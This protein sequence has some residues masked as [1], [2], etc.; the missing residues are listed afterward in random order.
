MVFRKNNGLTMIELLIVTTIIALFILVAIFA[1]QLQL[2]KGRDARRKA[3]LDKIQN[4]LEDYLNDKICY[5]EPEE[6]VTAEGYI[7][8]KPFAPYLSSLPCDPLNNTYYNYFYSYDSTKTCKG[9]YKIYTKLENTKD[10]IIEKVGCTGG[11][12]PSGNY[13][14]W[15]S[16]PNMNQVAPIPLAEDWWPS[17]AGVSPPPGGSPTPPPGGTPTPSPIP[18]V[19][20]SP[21]PTPT[22]VPCGDGGVQ[23]NCWDVKNQKLYCNSNICSTCCP[24]AEYRCNLTATCCFYDLTCL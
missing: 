14:Y 10:P 1:Y 18:G 21:T 8:G 5:P 9:W 4:V 24:G 15:V 6:I 16:S 17:I 19:S 20:P 23:P 7:C 13:N 2:A 12:G 22:L 3:D 11:C